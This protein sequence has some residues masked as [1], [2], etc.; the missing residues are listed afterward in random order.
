MSLYSLIV[1]PNTP[2][3]HWVQLGQVE[4]PDDDLAAD[5]YE[6]AIAR[7]A[8]AGYLQYEVSNWARG[9]GGA[10]TPAYACRH[11]L[12][13]WRN[14]DYLG[15]GPGAHSHLRTLRQSKVARASGAGAT[16]S[17][18]QATSSGY[19]QAIPSRNSTRRSTPRLAMGETMM[20]GLR[21]LRE[22][23]PRCA[24]CGSAW[25]GSGRRVC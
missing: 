22:G 9:N 12:I 7:L 17:R 8:D 11:N 16:A 21:L 10:E 23:V 3:Y 25:Q 6:L 20:L 4:A 13:Y 18:F 14:D 1:E 24:L 5:L 2:L 15:I 19:A